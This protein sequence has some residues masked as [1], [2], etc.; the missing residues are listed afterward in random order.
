[1]KLCKSLWPTNSFVKLKP[2]KMPFCNYT[3]LGS[4]YLFK[5]A[6]IQYNKKSSNFSEQNLYSGLILHAL[7]Y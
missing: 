4:V 2:W 6:Q 7:R 3:L 5:I 1:M